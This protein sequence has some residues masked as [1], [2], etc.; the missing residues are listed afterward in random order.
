MNE[1]LTQSFD[2]VSRALDSVTCDGPTRRALESA[3]NQIRAA[4]GA[5]PNVPP[6]PPPLPKP[7]PRK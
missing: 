7:A 5:G 4:A 6:P 3:W 1:Q 2:L